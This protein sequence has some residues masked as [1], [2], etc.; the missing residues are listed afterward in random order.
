MTGGLPEITSDSEAR[1]LM[2]GGLG[3]AELEFATS[4][5]APLYWVIRQEDGNYVV[6][7]GSAFFLDAGAGP[8]AVTAHHVIEGW[9]RDHECGNV[10][11]FQLGDQPLDLAGRNAVIGAHAGLDVATFRFSAEDVA[12]I[13]KIV[14]TGYQSEWP[15]N[16]PLIDRGVYYAGFPGTETI[17]LSQDEISFGAAPG[18]GVASSVSET[19]VSSLIS[20]EHLI[21]VLGGGVPPE[22][23]DFGGMS[24]GPMLMVI[25]HR[26]LRSWSLA[27]V[28]YEGPNPSPDE[29]Q[30]ILGLE[31]IRARR[32]HFILPDGTFDVRRWNALCS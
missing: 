5:T 3:K 26:G 10:V 32:A 16:P 20:R 14:L 19:D 15:P 25:E 28:I 12:S 24:G 17:W 18:G 27:G 8:F 6:R 30:A 29:R 23:Y 11:A 31:I 1:A 13:G 4:V 7:N 21:G 9:R 2:A 22:N